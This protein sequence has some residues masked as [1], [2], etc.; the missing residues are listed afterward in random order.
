MFRCSC[1]GGEHP[2]YG[3]IVK[4]WFWNSTFRSLK[5]NVIEP[6]PGMKSD[7]GGKRQTQLFVDFDGRT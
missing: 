4:N 7:F 2:K 1:K 3:T 5:E 6:W